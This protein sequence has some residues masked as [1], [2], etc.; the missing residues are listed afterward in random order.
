[1]GL[2]HYEPAIDAFKKQLEVNPYDEYAYN[3][4]GMAYTLERRYNEAESAFRKQLE[5]NPLDKFAHAALGRMYVEAK[6]YADAIPELEK[7]I[8]L[9]PDL[10]SLQID[11]GTA[12]LNTNNA[13]RAMAAFAR[14][15]ELSPT[16]TTWN[17]VAYQL[18]LKGAYL[19]RAQQ[20]AESAVS[21]VAADSRNF[22]IGHITARELG[23]T[24]SIASYLDTLGWVAFAKGDLVS[25]EK[26]VSAAWWISEHAEVGDH[27]GQ[28]ATRAG[29]KD[30]AIRWYA[31][32]LTAE[33]PEE[34]T[35]GRLAEVAGTSAKLDD[36][37]RQYAPLL[38]RLRSVPVKA[39]ASATGSGD[40]FLLVGT[41][42][43]VEEAEFTSG[44]EKLKP[45]SASLKALQFPSLGGGSQPVKVIRRATL[46]CGTE[47]TLTLIPSSD[48]Q[49]PR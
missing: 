5:L 33:R 48:A 18:A 26:L 34:G 3:N 32:S 47:C 29:K 22:S 43:R 24:Q 42:G 10:A 7:G 21:A 41:D 37:I 46:A 6:R 9:A 25:A 14:A 45:M 44:E 1:M 2:R 23:I 40:F 19:D 13:E 17:N 4:L 16:P 12:H 20:F 11:L 30:E 28:I 31:L 38:T 35:R 36:I 27:L 8:S 49:P 39:T 15:A